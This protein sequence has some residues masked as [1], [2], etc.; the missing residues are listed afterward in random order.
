[1]NLAQWQTDRELADCGGK[2]HE[3]RR[4]DPSRSKVTLVAR[5]SAP[6][7]A[8]SLALPA[9]ARHPWADHETAQEDPV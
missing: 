8:L 7:L 1:M 6:P 5:S 9:M 3:P 2:C 4:R